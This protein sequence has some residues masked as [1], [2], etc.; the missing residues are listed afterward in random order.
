MSDLNTFDDFPVGD[1]DND[2]AL[3]RASM[4]GTYL[5]ATWLADALR[6]D[7]V[8]APYV[9]EEPGW[10]SRGRPPSDFSFTPHFVLS[11]HTACGTGTTPQ[12]CIQQITYNGNSG[13][14]PPISQLLISRE[15]IVYILAAGRA[16][17]AGS[18]TWMDGT[19]GNGFAIGIE[20][21]NNGTGE[22]WGDLQVELYRR[23]AAAIFNH[24]G[25]YSTDRVDTHFA[26]THRK[27]NNDNVKIDP[28]GPADFWPQGGTWDLG[29]WQN[30]VGKYIGDW[31]NPNPIPPKPNP[32]PESDDMAQVVAKEG[33]YAC[34]VTNQCVRTWIDGSKGGQ[35]SRGGSL[36]L[37]QQLFECNQVDG[38]V[39][40]MSND[41]MM[42]YVKMVGQLEGYGIVVGPD[43]GDV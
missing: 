21:C 23:T 31:P 43:P 42:Q 10:E 17:H 4:K 6:A 26:Y 34:W 40:D 7:P 32:N 15:P 16:N 13:A 29:A 5:W 18:G 20:V 36:A 9:V 41:E 3:L 12:Q 39:F 14:P 19:E 30:E 22:R 33:K 37:A 24:F 1:N 38:T 28:A 11:H 35:T 27:P 25:Y 8:L 2:I